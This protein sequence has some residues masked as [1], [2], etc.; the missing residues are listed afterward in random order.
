MINQ[1]SNFFSSYSFSLLLLI[2][3]CVFFS[4][5]RQPL[6]QIE[7]FVFNRGMCFDLLFIYCFWLMFL[8]N[9]HGCCYEFDCDCDER[10]RKS[11]RR[12][13]TKKISSNCVECNNKNKNKNNKNNYYT[14]SNSVVFR[15]KVLAILKSNTSTVLNAMFFY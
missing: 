5:Y 1:K 12:N 13:S 7:I 9:Y 3:L 10:Y 2:I 8:G 14:S 15:S 4:S 11:M 6:I